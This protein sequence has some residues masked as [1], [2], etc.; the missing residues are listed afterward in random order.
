M[1]S[2]EIRTYSDA[3]AEEAARRAFILALRRAL[4]HLYDIVE[5]RRNPLCA[6]FH[7]SGSNDAATLRQI[8]EDGI[9]ALKPASGLSP[10]SDAWRTYRALY[11]RYVEQFDQA[12]VAVNLGLSIR[13]MRRQEQLALQTLAD[14]LIQRYRLDLK[15]HFGHA[16][17]DDPPVRRGGI[18]AA[19]RNSAAQADAPLDGVAQELTWAAQAFPSQRIN[20]AEAV[21]AALRTVQ[22]IAD[23]LDISLHSEMPDD[24]LPALA[25]AVSTR[26]ILLN[27]LLTA[28][29]S[30]DRVVRIVGRHSAACV[31][32]EISPIRRRTD[33]DAER[34]AIV[35][36][37]AV[38]S[39]GRLEYQGTV[40]AQTACVTLPL[41][42]QTTVLVVDD[43]AD[44]LRLFERYLVNS[45]YRFA[46]A[47]D[48]EQALTLAAQL[49]P[50]V[51][52]LDVM[53]PGVDGWEILGRLRE[54]PETCHIPV[55][56]CT[57]L[58]Q[59]ELAA[60]LGAAGFIRKP[61]T[62][63]RLLLELDR[64]MGAAATIPGS[65]SPHTPAVD[66]TIVPPGA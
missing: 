58:P 57:I 3:S 46:G 32:L 47:R 23:A 66:A 56:I 16:T 36:R 5:L 43:N 2:Q 38:I 61:V 4:H 29:R 1:S 13:Q 42:G 35:E 49:R 25:Q 14:W 48:P 63:D 59:E 26:Q 51:I 19:D 20:L 62:R 27:L 7:L 34:L 12:S 8:L 64:Q 11:H 33:Q 28:I 10:T 6:L 24:L 53:L 52:V 18:A 44:S 45:P 50:Q 9:L 30:G 37:L 22:P 31:Q 21:N 40:Q 65:S 60:T 54:H 17:P 41:A 15:L 39:G 55:I